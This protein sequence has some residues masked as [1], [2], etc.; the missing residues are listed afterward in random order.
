M[1][2]ITP[3]C[4]VKPIITL[5]LWMRKHWSGRLSHLPPAAQLLHDA[6]Q[7]L[8]RQTVKAAV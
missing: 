1:L 5:T 8:G 6:A 7:G 4:E 3:P 2:I